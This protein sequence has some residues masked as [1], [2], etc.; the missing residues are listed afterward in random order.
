MINA[1]LLAA[2]QMPEPALR[3]AVIK[4]V[5]GAL[6][7]FALLTVG[8]IWGVGELS[9]FVMVS[10]GWIAG[11]MDAVLSLAGGATVIL[12]IFFLFPVIAISATSL[13]LDP[14]ID[15]V[16]A[17]YY[18]NL[19]APRKVPL[20]ESISQAIGF[21][22]VS[23]AVNILVLP[24]YL[25]PGVNVVLFYVVNG[26]LAGREYLEMVAT[27]RKK[28]ATL[29]RLRKSRAGRLWAGGAAITFLLTVPIVNLLAP[30]LGAAAFVHL[31]AADLEETEV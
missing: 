28:S 25:I 22:G 19:P 26:Y 9:A 31:L 6:G 30:V 3:G 29:K 10:E 5:L 1:F 7:F 20:G 15:A 8:V 13:F 11:L 27:R 17:R 23:L 18:P 2:R 12:L 21:L 24:L 16:E 14:V 4:G